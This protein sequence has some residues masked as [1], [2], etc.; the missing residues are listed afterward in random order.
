MYQEEQM[1][2]KPTLEQHIAALEQ[3]KQ[4][5][6][7]YIYMKVQEGDFHGVADGA[8]DVR[9]IEAEI[10]GIRKAIEHGRKL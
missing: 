9:D 4:F 8:M 2:N 3:K 6:I 7:Q 5:M 10:L 1:E